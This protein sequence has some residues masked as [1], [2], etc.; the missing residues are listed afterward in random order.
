[1]KVPVGLKN[2]FY[3]KV[4]SDDHTG[5][6]YGPTKRFAP[7]ISANVNPTINSATLNAEDG[8]LITANALGEIAVEVGAADIPF[9]VRADVLGAKLNTDGVLI[10][11]ADDQAPEIALGWERTLH[12]GTSRFVWLLK[13][14]FRLPAE[15]ATTK[16]GE[17]SFQTPTITGTFLKRVY[18]GNW[19]FQVEQGRDGTPQSVIDD[20]FTEVYSGIPTP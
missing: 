9:D 16:Q 18:D 10:Y 6:S 2:I 7:A 19:M 14:K 15:E 20:W 1:M 5:V 3:A 8:P 11:N 17:V 13:G 4:L 12:D